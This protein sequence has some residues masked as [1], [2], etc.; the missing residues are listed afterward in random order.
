MSKLHFLTITLHKG[1]MTV[2]SAP[3][4]PNKFPQPHVVRA[5]SHFRLPTTL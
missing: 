5:F 2:E 3:S 4:L 1:A